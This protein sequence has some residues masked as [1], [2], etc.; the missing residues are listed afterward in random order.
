M[1]KQGINERQFGCAG[2][3][4]NIFHAFTLQHFKEN[5]GARSHI[6]I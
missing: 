4:K 2:V 3:A 5:I 1:A 6:E